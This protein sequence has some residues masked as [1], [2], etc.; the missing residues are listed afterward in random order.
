MMNK[1]MFVIILFLST[2]CK[3]YVNE[4]WGMME[5]QGY[6][7]NDFIEDH[8]LP[9]EAST[10]RQTLIDSMVNNANIRNKN[11]NIS[12]IIISADEISI[13]L[14]QEQIYGYSFIYIKKLN[15]NTLK[16]ASYFQIS[17][18]INTK[19]NGLE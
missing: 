15:S 8:V 17:Y 16:D 11:I 19:K 13:L 7:L 9:Y 6:T 2:G 10:E 5:A 18:Y 12:D 1:I 14:K 3:L 4:G